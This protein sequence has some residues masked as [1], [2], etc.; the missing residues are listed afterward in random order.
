[1]INECVL[2]GNLVANPELRE[3]PNSDN[4]VVSF[5][6]AINNKKKNKQTGQYEDDPA[7]VDCEAW[8]QTAKSINEYFTKG[9]PIVVA[10]SIQQ[11][12]WKDKEAGN[13]RSRLRFRVNR[14]Y[15]PQTV[16]AA[17]EQAAPADENNDTGPEDAPPA[18]ESGEDIPF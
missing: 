13:P 6:I 2:G 9:K 10:A 15:F 4:V 5:T 3:I 17:V 14:F 16:K 12:R 18:R 8:G 11:E 7:F 1:M